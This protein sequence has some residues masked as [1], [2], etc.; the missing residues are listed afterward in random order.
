MLAEQVERGELPP[1]AERLPEDPYV[2]EP[3]EEIGQY[4]GTA[5]VATI[6]PESWGDDHMMMSLFNGIVKPDPET[7]E[8]QPHFAHQIDVSDD[9]SS[10][11]FHFRPGVKW[12]DGEP[13]TTED[14]MFWYEDVL[15]NEELTPAISPHFK[16]QEEV[17]TVEALDKYTVRFT[18]AGPK[19]LFLQSLVHV[20]GDLF[21]P[22]HYLSQFH[23]NYV[24]EDELN[25]Q[26]REAGFDN[27]FALFGNRDNR[28]AQAPMNVERP[29][30]SSYQY[31]AT[32]LS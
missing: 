23:P 3:L 6:R 5:Q 8:L 1:V 25:R 19:P 10:Y 9:F 11:T 4:G 28:V 7:G 22:K 15:L 20:S 27:W 21:L 2:V 32:M 17:V 24:P 30:L 13:F 14:I 18:F 31:S 29:T 12:S 16:F 26:M